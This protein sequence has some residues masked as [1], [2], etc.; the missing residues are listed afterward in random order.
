MDTASKI[1]LLDGATGTELD[2][3]GVSVDL[4][5]WSAGAIL[6]A[7]DVLSAIHR[8]YLEAGARAITANTFRTH[9][10]SLQKAGLE[11]PDRLTRRAVELAR[12]ACLSINPQALVLGSVA[13]LEDCYSPEL[14]PPD[15]GPEHRELA[16]VLAGAGVDLLL[17]ET[18]P[19]VGEGLAA[20]EACVATG[21]E[22]WASFTA[23][24][25]ADL[26]TPAEVGRG[27]RQAVDLGASAVLVNCIPAQHTLAFVRAL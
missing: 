5:G 6:D 12:E 1:L 9:R 2:R 4:P 14:S 15:P 26:L 21:V 13:P 8:E 17:C 18:F 10:R 3:R 16:E 19:H 27:A 7:P 24:P 11:D 22:T 20:V 25:R 23:G